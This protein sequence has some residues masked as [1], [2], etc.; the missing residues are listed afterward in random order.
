MTNSPARFLLVLL[1]AATSS[2]DGDPF[3]DFLS[4][5]RSGS[6]DRRREALEAVLA[7][8]GLVPEGSVDRARRLLLDVLE[9]DSEAELRGLAGRCLRH[10]RSTETD[11]R[12][13]QQ[14]SRERDHRSQRALL[15]A[16]SGY[17]D[18][19][20]AALVEKR[21][22]REPREDVRCLWVEALGRS[23]RPEA[24]E[25]LVRLARAPAPWPIGQAAAVALAEHPTPAVVDVLIDLLWSGFDGVR[26]AAHESLEQVTG[27][28][29]LPAEAA[30]WVEWWGQVRE[31][32]EFPGSK[33]GAEAGDGDVQTVP[34]DPA[35]LPTYYDIPIRG[36]RVIFVMDISASMW[37]PKSEAALAELSR[38]VR[39]LRTTNRFNVIFFN[40][41]PYPW[42]K[43]LLPAFPYQKLECVTSFQE[44][45][46]KKYTNIYNSI[47]RA[48]GFAGLGRFALEDPPGVDDVFVLTDGEPNRGRYRDQRG[49]LAGLDALDPMKRV[50]IHAI[51][52][53][54]APKD[55]MQAIAKQHGGRH[56]HIDARR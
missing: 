50:R 46:T 31:G 33:P 45:E 26:S 39:T 48:L 7:S 3:A 8:P 47:E 10:F 6:E 52:I 43:E 24:L 42:R 2:A 40:E 30:R 56:V 12:I 20:L 5:A 49:I 34:S 23:G 16:V 28:R 41:H 44:L 54:D 9:K 29:D 1:F 55:L 38:A 4:G 18:E 35:T 14:L 19:A 13:L 11:G 17:P 15:D 21:A 37:G 25:T 27:N 51:S 22:F 53:G 36:R 32:F